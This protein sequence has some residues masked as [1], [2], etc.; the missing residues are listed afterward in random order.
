MF[1]QDFW[2]KLSFCLVSIWKAALIGFVTPRCRNIRSNGK[3]QA[4]LH[5]ENAPSK[6]HAP[7][8]WTPVLSELAGEKK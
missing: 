7:R 2:E 8:G 1:L 5:S 3:A 6:Q 4:D